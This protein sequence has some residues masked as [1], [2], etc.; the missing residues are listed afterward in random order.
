MNL[1][2]R[3]PPHLRIDAAIV[4]YA[5]ISTWLVFSGL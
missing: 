2:R 3:F 1:L 5:L 4:T